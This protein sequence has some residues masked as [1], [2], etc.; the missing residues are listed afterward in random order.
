[1]KTCPRCHTHLKEHSLGELRIDMCPGCDGSWYDNEELA[2]V[3]DLD[4]PLDRIAGSDLSPILV[5]DK[6]ADLQAE[7]RCPVC[8]QPMDRYRYQLV[9]DIELDRCLEH[10]V[11][12]DDGELARVVDY[13]IR[14]TAELDPETEARVL[15]ELQ[16]IRDERKQAMA[17]ELAR[18]PGLLGWVRRAMAAL[19]A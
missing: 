18:Q 15:A 16:K 4:A 9:S 14:S 5:A 6:S 8:E 19:T 2:Q 13:F 12:L 10:G 11:W 7:A 3:M 1:M 17:Q